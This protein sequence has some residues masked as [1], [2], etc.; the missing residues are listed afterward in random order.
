MPILQEKCFGQKKQVK[1]FGQTKNTERGS[2]KERKG[3]KTLEV[4]EDKE[5]TPVKGYR[6][7][8]DKKQNSQIKS[9]NRKPIEYPTVNEKFKIDPMQTYSKM[10]HNL[11][12]QSVKPFAVIFKN[13]NFL[14]NL[15]IKI[16][17]NS[18]S[19]KIESPDGEPLKE[20]IFAIVF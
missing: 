7:F 12:V 20:T 19:R 14:P 9:Q 13:S 2:S 17:S 16:S 18:S 3:F 1:M 5:N 6:K 15:K 10:P 11:G 8:G 4:E